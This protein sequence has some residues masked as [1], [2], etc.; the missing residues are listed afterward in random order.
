[1]NVFTCQVKSLLQN[2]IF[3]E[4]LQTLCGSEKIDLA[5]T[6]KKVA[7]VT[8]SPVAAPF[9]L[10]GRYVCGS[11]LPC[12]KYASNLKDCQEE[13]GKPVV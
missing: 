3:S 12:G 2:D 10:A 5:G 8:V 7:V 9:I 11:I 6:N 4:G 1:M 13:N